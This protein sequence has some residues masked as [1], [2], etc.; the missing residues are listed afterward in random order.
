MRLFPYW[1]LRACCSQFYCRLKKAK[2]RCIEVF[3]YA[4]QAYVPNEII[5]RI[6]LEEFFEQKQKVTIADLQRRFFR[7][8]DQLG[9]PREQV[10]VEDADQRRILVRKK[11]NTTVHSKSFLIKFSYI[12][13]L[14]LLAEQLELVQKVEIVELDHIDHLDMDRELNLLAKFYRQNQFS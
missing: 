2:E 9:I 11:S 6:H 7:V 5:Y 10:K 13:T 3:G 1:I 4:E 8:V 12:D 14:D